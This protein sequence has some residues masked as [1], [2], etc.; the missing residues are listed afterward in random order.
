MSEFKLSKSCELAGLPCEEGFECCCKPCVKAFE[1]DVF[2]KTDVNV[3]ELAILKEGG[4][5]T[6]NI[7]NPK[8]AAVRS[9]NC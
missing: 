9:R 4:I 5:V 2:E 6:K 3:T 1:V 8:L 7:L